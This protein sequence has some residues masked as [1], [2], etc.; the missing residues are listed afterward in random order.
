MGLMHL[1]DFPPVVKRWLSHPI[2]ILSCLG[3]FQRLSKL[4]STGTTRRNVC[5]GVEV[6][7]SP[8]AI[9]SSRA[10]GGETCCKVHTCLPVGL[11]RV[12]MHKRYTDYVLLRIHTNTYIYIYIYGHPPPHDPPTSILYGNYQCFMHIFLPEKWHSHVSI[13]FTYYVSCRP[14]HTH[15]QFCFCL[16][17]CHFLRFWSKTQKT[18]RKPKKPKKTKLQDPCRYKLVS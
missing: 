9:P 1:I 10:V 7:R 15:M 4:W 6:W 16:L 11:N 17:F 13:S 18:L 14:R 3:S 12:F 5:D 2:Q 8:L